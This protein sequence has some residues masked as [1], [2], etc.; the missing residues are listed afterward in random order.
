[1]RSIYIAFAVAL[2][3]LSAAAQDKKDSAPQSSASVLING[4]PITGR[5]LEVDGKHFVAVEDLAQNLNGTIAYSEGRVALTL[6]QP[7]V[8]TDQRSSSEPPSMISQAPSSPQPSVPAQAPSS[9][10]A[11]L[12]LQPS[13]N[14]SIKGK[15]TYFFDV[16]TGHK[17]DAGSK[18]WLVKGHV[19][20]P[21]DQNFVGTSTALGTSNNPEQYVAIKY[22][23][24]NEN[25]SFELLDVP[26]GEYTLIMQSAHTK[27]ALREKRSF[28]SRGN[29]H[30]LRDSAGRVESLNLIVKAGEAVDASKDFGPNIEM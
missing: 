28:F 25:G 11:S 1:L 21:E 4:K 2:L 13:G 19:E 12:P 7:P 6:S 20:I 16:H 26:A 14:G 27:G 9:P 23:T 29:G 10:P 22:S 3:T 5:V 15:L 24:A 17:P 18:I 30:T 8:V